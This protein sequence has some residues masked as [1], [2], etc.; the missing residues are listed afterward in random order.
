MRRF[1]CRSRTVAANARSYAHQT[2]QRMQGEGR[3][4]AA[5]CFLGRSSGL[6]S[7]IE[8]PSSI[9]AGG[10]WVAG[11]S[12]GS[13][14]FD[15]GVVGSNP[16]RPSRARAKTGIPPFGAAFSFPPESETAHLNALQVG[17]SV[18]T[19][20]GKRPRHLLTEPGVGYR[21]ISDEA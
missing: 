12:R 20:T 3:R 1:P 19:S 15:P 10:A 17:R 13:R 4:R 11:S 18:F 16:T 8:A 14:T 9:L 21:L 2:L 7:S 5:S 6:G